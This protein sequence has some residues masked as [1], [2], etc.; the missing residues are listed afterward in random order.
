MLRLTIVLLTVGMAMPVQGFI[1]NFAGANMRLGMPPK[2]QLLQIRNTPLAVQ[3]PALRSTMMMAVETLEKSKTEDKA[4]AIDTPLVLPP[5]P[6][7]PVAPIVRPNP[8]FLPFLHVPAPKIQNLTAI[9]KYDQRAPVATKPAGSALAVG[10]G[11]HSCEFSVC[12][13]VL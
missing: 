10:L 7:V 12:Q 9:S 5:T 4:S 2:F 13:F 11:T 3:K 1:S 6:I 8:A